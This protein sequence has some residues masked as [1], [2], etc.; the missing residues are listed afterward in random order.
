MRDEADR[1]VDRVRAAQREVHMAQRCRR[2]FHQAGR[3]AD[4]GLG[5]EV[6]IAGRVRELAHLLGCRAHD[7]VLAVADVDAPEAGKRVEQF[8][9]VGI[10]Q[11]G[12]MAG[13]EDRGAALLVAAVIHDG[14]D[15]VGAVQRGELGK[16][17]V[18]HDGVRVAGEVARLW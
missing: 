1:R 16:F 6:E 14:M 9:A 11:V 7:A 2:Q 3:Q 12:A 4:R 13:D 15:K 17:V 18:V 10:G 8:V 5:R